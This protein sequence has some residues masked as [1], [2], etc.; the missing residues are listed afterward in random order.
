MCET[1]VAQPAV[2]VINDDQSLLESRRMLLEACGAK[3]LTACGEIMAIHEAIVHPVDLVLI[4][5]TNVGLEH[6]EKV[7]TV[8]RD[9]RP[10]QLIGLLIQTEI[11]TPL[12]TSADRVIPRTGPRRILV[13]AN[14]MLEGRLNL[15]L[16]R[17][18]SQ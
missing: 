8:V 10:N 9:I 17:D 12:K 5:A 3:V 15:D 6:G 14:E 13:E 16:W 11:G 4:D 2:L 18:G 1:E 7:C